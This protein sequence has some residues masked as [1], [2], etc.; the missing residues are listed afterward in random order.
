MYFLRRRQAH[1]VCIVGSGAGGAMAAK[2]LTDAGADVVMLEAGPM[3]DNTR[4]S[5]MFT[6]PYEAPY[7]GAATPERHFGE[8]DAG[9]GGWSL[10]GEP[11]TQAE[12]RGSTGSAFECS[13]VARITGEESHCDLV[14]TIFVAAHSRGSAMT[15]RSR[16]TT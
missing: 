5:A 15:G 1:D 2:V 16:M 10:P 13:G 12:E 9:L 3:W 4:D 6:W 7:R 14:L 8:F 11:Y